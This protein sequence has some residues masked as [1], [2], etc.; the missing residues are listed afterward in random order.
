M[1]TGSEIL[2]LKITTRDAYILVEPSKGI[3]FLEVLHGL[4]KL[5][6]M[7]EFRDRNDVWV[8]CDGKMDITYA[9]LYKIKEYVIKNFPQTSR[10][11]KTAIVVETG[12]QKSI[13]ELYAKMEKELPHEIR[14]FSDL[15]SAEEWI[16]E[17]GL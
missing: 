1:H 17:T 7:P 5:L 3:D 14:V 2:G 12:M 11:R 10:V 9:D 16:K 13:A 8:F 6:S 4:S 15:K